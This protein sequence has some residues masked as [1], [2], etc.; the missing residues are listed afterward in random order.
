MCE[1]GF[2]HAKCY[3]FYG[4][5]GALFDRFLPLIGIVGS[6]NFTAPGLLT[7]KELYLAPKTLL[8]PDEINDAPARLV[9]ERASQTIADTNRRILKSKS[10]QRASYFIT[11]GKKLFI[12]FEFCNTMP[13][14]G[15]KVTVA[16]SE[17]SL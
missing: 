15:C 9:G 7:N 5:Q 14:S 6:S 11:K 12:V 2:R 16:A 1:N 3:L 8:E 13:S 10:R 4:D 17:P